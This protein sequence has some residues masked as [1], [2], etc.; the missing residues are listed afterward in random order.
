[1]A[2]LEKLLES[3]MLAERIR[4]QA[5]KSMIQSQ[6]TLKELTKKEKITE[7]VEDDGIEEEESNEENNSS[8][9]RNNVKKETIKRKDDKVKN[10]S[11]ITHNNNNIGACKFSVS[12][13]LSNFTSHLAKSHQ[14]ILQMTSTTASTAASVASGGFDHTSVNPFTCFSTTQPVSLT[15]TGTTLHSPDSPS[16]SGNVAAAAAAQSAA[17]TNPYFQAATHG[18]PQAYNAAADFSSYMTANTNPSSWYG[19]P[20]PRFTLGRFPTTG[21]GLNCGIDP[22][23]AAVHGI[24]LP[25]HNNQRRKR[26]VLFSQQQVFELERRFKT[27]RYLTAPEREALANSINLTPTQ[28]KIWFQNHRYKCKRQEKEKAMTG[29]RSSRASVDVSPDESR[30][31]TPSETAHQNRESLG[32]LGNAKEEIKSETSGENNNQMNDSLIL[33]SMNGS[34]DQLGLS[35][36]NKTNQLYSQYHNQQQMY[37]QQGFAFATFNPTATQNYQAVN[38]PYYSQMKQASGW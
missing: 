6:S 3:A 37:A 1:M 22:S 9:G 4:L 21:M 2:M 13:L 38:N 12:D 33:N 17:L 35:D 32:I 16:H 19:G 20:D 26:R 23:R 28:V 36:L 14:K 8:V 11:T 29:E 34:F 30:N 27:Q 5:M 25:I 24:Q 7:M 10:S 18:F 15:G 31:S